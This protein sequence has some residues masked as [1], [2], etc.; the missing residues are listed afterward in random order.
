[1]TPAAKSRPESAPA[2]GGAPPSSPIFA[3]LIVDGN[4]AR[5]VGREGDGVVVRHGEASL[6][7]GRLALVDVVQF[8]LHLHLLRLRAVLLAAVPAVDVAQRYR[9]DTE[10]EHSGRLQRQRLAFLIGH[11]QCIRLFADFLKVVKVDGREVKRCR[12][13]VGVGLTVVPLRAIGRELPVGE[14]EREVV[15]VVVGVDVV[16]VDIREDVLQLAVAIVLAPLHRVNL[17]FR[18]VYMLRNELLDF[19]KSLVGGHWEGFA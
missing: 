12:A 16:D 8:E 3:S 7:F 5:S 9:P 4:L 19:G 10:T 17:I 14:L 13:G 18:S 2:V 1:M 6:I 15:I 11:Y